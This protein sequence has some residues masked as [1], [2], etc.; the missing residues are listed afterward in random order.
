MWKIYFKI[1]L[2]L[3]IPNTDKLQNLWY[4]FTNDTVRDQTGIN[5]SL[6][7]TSGLSSLPHKSKSFLTVQK[8]SKDKVWNK[9]LN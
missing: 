9:Y 4:F 2:Q 1:L 7:L 8:G 3:S 6:S 5:S